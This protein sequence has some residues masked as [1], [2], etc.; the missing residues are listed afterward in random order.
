MGAFLSL[1]DGHDRS[2]DSFPID[3][4]TGDRQAE[5]SDLRRY[6]QDSNHLIDRDSRIEVVLNINRTSS[7]ETA[8]A[9]INFLSCI[10]TSVKHFYRWIALTISS[11]SLCALAGFWPVITFPLTTTFSPHGSLALTY[12]PPVTLFSSVSSTRTFHG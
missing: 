10:I 4:D 12:L 2:D 3:L 1:P 6:S 8:G 7:S 5:K 11:P 9:C